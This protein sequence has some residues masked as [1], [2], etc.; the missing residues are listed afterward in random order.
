[1]KDQVSFRVFGID[2]GGT[3]TSIID[4]VAQVKIYGHFMTINVPISKLSASE[5]TLTKFTELVI[6]VNYELLSNSN[7]RYSIAI[8]KDNQE[9]NILVCFDYDGIMSI[10]TEE[11]EEEM[12]PTAAE[13]VEFVRIFEHNITKI[14]K[15]VT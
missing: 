9:K 6:W 11:E 1:M 13:V 10:A 14:T 2:Y 3:I 15:P 7:I 5:V 8:P 4:N 12:N